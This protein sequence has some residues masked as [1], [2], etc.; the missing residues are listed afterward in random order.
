MHITCQFFDLDTKI[1]KSLLETAHNF[2]NESLHGSYINYFE[3]LQVKST[4]LT[5]F[6]AQNLKDC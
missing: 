4:I 3:A 6:L 5:P 1:N 2:R